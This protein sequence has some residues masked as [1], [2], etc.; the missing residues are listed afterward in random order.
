[1]VGHSIIYFILIIQIPFP[2]DVLKTNY[3]KLGKDNIH[4][5]VDC[6]NFSADSPLEFSIILMIS[7]DTFSLSQQ[8]TLALLPSES[9]LFYFF[10]SGKPRY[11]SRWNFLRNWEPITAFIPKF[12]TLESRVIWNWACSTSLYE[13]LIAPLTVN[14]CLFTPRLPWSYEFFIIT[15]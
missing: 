8:S 9:V 14:K 7:E 10:F 11:K 13:C 4:N 1:M 6:E 3:L 12:S 5:V 2:S 15:W